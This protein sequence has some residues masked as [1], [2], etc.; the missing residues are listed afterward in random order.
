MSN[1]HRNRSFQ[2]GGEIYIREKGATSGMIAF[3]NA[4][5]FSFAINEEK[6]TQRNFQQPGGGNIASQSSISDVVLSI[7]GLS[8]KPDTLAL[9]LRS[10]VTVITG[11]AITAEPHVAY[12]ESF[13]PLSQIPDT[14]ET[15]TVTD[16]VGTLTYTLNTDYVVKQGGIFITENSTIPDS[17]AGAPNI[18][19]TYT[20][21][22]AF[23]IEGI[24]RSAVDY[25]LFFSGFND[26]DNGKPVTVKC[27]KIKFSPSQALELISADFGALPLTA[28]VLADDSIIATDL[29]KY[30]VVNMAA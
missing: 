13:V 24:T 1:R 22:D 17:V 7:N 10:L 26:A 11:I 16:T 4:D 6:K 27:H 21:Q 19:V 28:E 5:S 2:G 18:K 12:K 23:T 8:F 14:S 25:E 9:G 20:S 30:L 15:F 3:G 29:S